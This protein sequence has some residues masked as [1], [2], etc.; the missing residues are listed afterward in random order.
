VFTGAGDHWRNISSES[1]AEVNKM[2]EVVQFIPK[3]DLDRA[4]LIREARAIY[5]GIF[6]TEKGP[7]SLQRDPKE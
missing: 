2:G 4:R 6:P 7:A 1:A 3:R 5:E